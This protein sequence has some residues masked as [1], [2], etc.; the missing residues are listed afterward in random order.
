MSKRRCPGQRV[1]MFSLGPLQGVLWC[2]N[3]GRR[4]SYTAFRT[5][6]GERDFAYHY[7]RPLPQWRQLVALS[8]QWPQGDYAA[9]V[10]AA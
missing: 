7:G 6:S 1:T 9:L 2:V 5:A 3:C 8:R 4:T 10:G